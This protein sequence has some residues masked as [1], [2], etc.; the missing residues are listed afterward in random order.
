MFDSAALERSGWTLQPGYLDD[1]D[2]LNI[3]NEL[4]DRMLQTMK[5]IYRLILGTFDEAY[6]LWNLDSLHDMIVHLDE[7]IWGICS[8]WFIMD[9]FS[10]THIYI[11]SILIYTYSNKY[12]LTGA[13]PKRSN[14]SVSCAGPVEGVSYASIKAGA[15]PDVPSAPL[16]ATPA[17]SPKV[18]PPPVA[19]GDRKFT[20]QALGEVVSPSLN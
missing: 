18:P 3:S 2:K 10:H 17:A 9:E 8:I 15:V 6:N 13:S 4:R 1:L 16:A 19:P 7:K 5:T 14:V 12:C 11:W 20:L